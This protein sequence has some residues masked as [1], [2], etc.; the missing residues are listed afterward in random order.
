MIKIDKN[1]PELSYISLIL[2]LSMGLWG[3]PN[4]CALSRH[5]D[6][7]R[8]SSMIYNTQF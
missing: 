8:L 7:N 6:A 3:R 5:L 2:R 1:N 4:S